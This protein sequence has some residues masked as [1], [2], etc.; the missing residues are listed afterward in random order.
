M[1]FNRNSKGFTYQDASKNISGV[2]SS[3]GMTINIIPIASSDD[4]TTCSANNFPLKLVPKD[5]TINPYKKLGLN[6]TIITSAGHALSLGSGI[7]DML[8]SQY[9]YLA[10]HS[11]I[12]KVKGFF[13]K[14]QDYKTK[15]LS[16]QLKFWEDFLREIFL[17]IN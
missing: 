1:S 6:K 13:P 7:S 4:S 5:S 2:L 14:D 12:L 9:D 3:D 16:R 17:T 10:E 15:M 11:R 8:S